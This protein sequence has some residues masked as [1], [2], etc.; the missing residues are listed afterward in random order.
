MLS[1]FSFHS[2]FRFFI[3]QIYRRSL[4]HKQVFSSFQCLLPSKTNNFEFKQQYEIDIVNLVH[5]YEKIINRS[6]QESIGE[7]R[8]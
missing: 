8:L 4:D 2:V 7:L 3:T 6:E 1:Y 5:R